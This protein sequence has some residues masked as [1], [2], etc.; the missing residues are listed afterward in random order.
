MDEVKKL[1]PALIVGTV[2]IVAY[3]LL[4]RIFALRINK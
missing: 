3:A 1:A 2:I 4:V